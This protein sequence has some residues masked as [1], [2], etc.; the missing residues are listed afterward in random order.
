MKLGNVMAAAALCLLCMADIH[1]ATTSGGTI[2]FNGSIAQT[3]SASMTAVRSSQA[4]PV[5]TTQVYALAEAQRRF[6][7]DVLDYFATYAPGNAK[8]ISVTYR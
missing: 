1:A 5:Q 8:L 3:A 6:S 4:E 7:S 2:T